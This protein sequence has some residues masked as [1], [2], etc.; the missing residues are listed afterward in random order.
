MYPSENTEALSCVLAALVFV[1]IA[2]FNLYFHI[3]GT[4]DNRSQSSVFSFEVRTHLQKFILDVRAA[5]TVT[6]PNIILEHG[7][8][9]IDFLDRGKAEE[10]ESTQKNP[11][12]SGKA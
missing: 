6:T 1:I 4:A 11:D 10:V 8:D 7:S 12:N 5:V 3:R 2:L 9:A